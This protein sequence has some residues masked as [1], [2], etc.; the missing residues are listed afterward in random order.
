MSC[1][2]ARGAHQFVGTSRRSS[3]NQCWTRAITAK[4]SRSPLLYATQARARKV[5]DYAV[6]HL[7][8]VEHVA[9]AHGCTHN[10]LPAKPELRTDSES[11]SDQ[12][13]RADSTVAD[14]RV[15]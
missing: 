5:G 15:R 6:Q 10:R 2:K 9:E 7:C 13:P 8:S 11:V 1:E 12:N 4:L 3:S 14:E